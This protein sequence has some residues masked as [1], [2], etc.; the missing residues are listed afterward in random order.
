M[1]L[2]LKE[3]RVAIV[4]LGLMGGSLGLALKQKQVCREVVGL[5]RRSD[6]IGQAESLGVVDVATTHP[7]VALLESD[8]VVFA[9]PIR[10]IV[11]QL[12]DLAGYYKAGAIITD[13]GSTKQEI[14]QAMATLP[15]G[16]Q[17]VGSHPMCGKETAGMEAAEASLF[18]A[19]TWVLTPL[20][21]SKPA[22]TE[23]VKEMAQA[24]GSKPITLAADR[25]DKLVATISHLP[26]A[27]AATLTLAAR[28][29]AAEDSAVW[30]VAASGFRDTSRVAAS[31]ET[32]MLDILM[33]NRQAVEEMVSEA[34]AQL[35]KFAKALASGDE[36]ALRQWMKSAAQ[37]RRKLFL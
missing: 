28:Q 13:M 23:I 11:W 36:K 20:E 18:E 7:G 2:K 34:R 29:V 25:H 12:V 15:E 26:Y 4:G 5:V 31:D 22:A 16:L 30:D 35:D 19:A 3:A 24:V 1:T 6:A 21:R 9:T 27:L 8:I 32:M 37:Q 14:I 33:T 17:P 10:T